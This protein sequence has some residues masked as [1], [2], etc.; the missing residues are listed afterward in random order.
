MVGAVA[1]HG[2]ADVDALSGEADE[3]GVVILALGL[4][5]GVVGAG[6]GVV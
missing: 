5:P 4:F 6:F 2:V 3:G 1:E